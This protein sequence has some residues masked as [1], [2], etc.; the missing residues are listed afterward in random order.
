MKMKSL[1]RLRKNSSGLPSLKLFLALAR[2]NSG[3]GRNGPGR[4][5]GARV[6]I[7]EPAAIET[8][9]DILPEIRKTRTDLGCTV[10][11]YQV[12]SASSFLIISTTPS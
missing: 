2:K 1:R 10:L 5:G 8:R 12:S 6:E 3:G 7:S 4:I 11:I 9:S